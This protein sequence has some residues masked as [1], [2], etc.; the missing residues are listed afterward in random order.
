MPTLSPPRKLTR[1]KP[2]NAAPISPG[3]LEPA[4]HFLSNERCARHLD[5]RPGDASGSGYAARAV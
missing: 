5:S 2:T 1:I 4:K 3:R